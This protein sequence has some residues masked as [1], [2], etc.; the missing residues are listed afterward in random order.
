MQRVR[1]TMYFLI[2]SNAADLWL[3]MQTADEIE[4][5]NFAR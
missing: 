4:V 2:V 5:K 1:C 3:V